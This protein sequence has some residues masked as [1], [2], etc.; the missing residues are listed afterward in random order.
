MRNGLRA[1]CILK[2]AR[3]YTHAEGLGADQVTNQRTKHTKHA[4][5][6]EK[7]VV[8]CAMPEASNL[9]RHSYALDD[10]PVF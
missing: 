2:I 6:A 4:T 8:C 9:I 3:I 10:S 7:A 1:T 5:G